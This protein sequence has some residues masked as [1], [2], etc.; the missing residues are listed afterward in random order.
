M[1]TGTRDRGQ[2]RHAQQ[3]VLAKQRDQTRD[4]GR[5]PRADV[6]LEETGGLAGRGVGGRVDSTIHAMATPGHRR[7]GSLQRAVHG[8]HAQV[9]EPG[10]LGRPPAQHVAQ[11]E[12]RSLAR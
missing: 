1:A 7:A 12:D 2:W 3:R 8:G 11:D 9:Q 6:A 10:D 5:L 4:V